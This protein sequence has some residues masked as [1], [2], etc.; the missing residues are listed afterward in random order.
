MA[1]HPNRLFPSFFPFPFFHARSRECSSSNPREEIDHLEP[2][3][4]FGNNC[5]YES[6]SNDDDIMAIT[7]STSISNRPKMRLFTVLFALAAYLLTLSSAAPGPIPLSLVERRQFRSGGGRGV[8][9]N[10]GSGLNLDLGFDP[11][12]SGSLKNSANSNT[13]GSACGTGTPSGTMWIAGQA[14]TCAPISG[15][16]HCV[17]TDLSD[18]SSGLDLC[19][20]HSDCGVG[21]CIKVLGKGSACWRTATGCDDYYRGGGLPL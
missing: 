4:S 16:N 1:T 8:G 17:A 18:Y 7:T 9:G 19:S 2:V 13:D 11:A 10:H 3:R 14:Y 21:W 5:F 12:K 15:V 6:S 20:K